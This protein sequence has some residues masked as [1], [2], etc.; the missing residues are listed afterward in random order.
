MKVVHC[1]KEKYDVYIG[2]PSKW[3]NPFTIDKDCTREQAVEKYREWVKKQPELMA[4]L[5][6]LEGKTLGCWCAPKACHGDILLQLANQ[7]STCNKPYIKNEISV[8]SNAYHLCRDCEYENGYITKQCAECEVFWGETTTN[9]FYD[10]A[11]DEN[12]DLETDEE[13]RLHYEK[14]EK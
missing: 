3:G 6:E 5:H 8:C 14:E 11:T 1:K 9:L 2:R 12:L 4:S 7:C 10:F 13:V